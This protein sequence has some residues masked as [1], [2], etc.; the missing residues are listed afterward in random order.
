MASR[1]KQMHIQQSGTSSHILE[2]QVQ[3]TVGCQRPKRN[4]LKASQINNIIN[5]WSKDFETEKRDAYESVWSKNERPQNPSG[6]DTTLNMAQL[7]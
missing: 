6:K 2:R 3:T 4:K 7:R 1:D 5:N